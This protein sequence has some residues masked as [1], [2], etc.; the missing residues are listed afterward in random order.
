MKDASADF[1]TIQDII[2]CIVFWSAFSVLAIMTYSMQKFMRLRL[3]EYQLFYVLGMKRRKMYGMILFEYFSG[4]LG[5]LFA[6]MLAGRLMLGGVLKA[7][8]YFFSEY[9]RRVPITVSVYM[10]TCKLSV[11]VFLAVAFSLLVW[12]DNH[13]LQDL[14]NDGKK[15]EKKPQSR[16]WLVFTVAGVLLIA[17]GYWIYA[18]YSLDYGYLFSHLFL[19]FGT[20]FC[21]FIWWRDLAR[22]T[23]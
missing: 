20:F 14:M 1:G 21:S 3:R 13:G 6:G 19:N 7:W 16:K 9:I 5:T 2:V 10:D 18:R 8:H 22:D 15:K 11:A 23:T 17:A 4:C 12:A